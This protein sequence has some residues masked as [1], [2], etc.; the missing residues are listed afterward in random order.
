M[1]DMDWPVPEEGVYQG[2]IPEGLDLESMTKD[3]TARAKKAYKFADNMLNTVSSPNVHDE[4]KIYTAAFVKNDLSTKYVEKEFEIEMMNYLERQLQES[5]KDQF[6]TS[7][8]K[9]NW[10]DRSSTTGY[11]SG[12]FAIIG[13]GV[14]LLEATPWPAKIYIAAAAGT[15]FLGT[16]LLSL[17]MKKRSEDLI[18]KLLD[19]DSEIKNNERR[20]EKSN[21]AIAEG[22][23]EVFVHYNQGIVDWKEICKIAAE[24]EAKD[25]NRLVLQKLDAGGD[26]GRLSLSGAD[27]MVGA[28][29]IANEAGEL[30][31]VPE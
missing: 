27:G 7:Q 26:L 28:V 11:I 1:T 8:A 3:Y 22:N 10:K 18:Y 12:A 21:I 15:I 25:K 4:L 30:E 6:D 23:Y 24:K 19:V 31:L 13:I 5:E 20:L 29:S 17:M 9:S 14:P 16:G 2:E